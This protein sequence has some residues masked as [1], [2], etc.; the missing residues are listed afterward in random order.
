M[1]GT[2]GFEVAGETHWEAI[3]RRTRSPAQAISTEDLIALTRVEGTTFQDEGRTYRFERGPAGGQQ[4]RCNVSEVG[5]SPSATKFTATVTY[6]YAL[7]G[8]FFGSRVPVTH[9]VVLKNPSNIARVFAPD[10][11]ATTGT[12]NVSTIKNLRKIFATAGI[13]PKGVV[14]FN[15]CPLLDSGAAGKSV[16]TVIAQRLLRSTTAEDARARVFQSLLERAPAARILFGG[17]EAAAFAARVGFKL[18]A[19]VS[20]VPD[21]KVRIAQRGDVAR[22]RRAVAILH[23]ALLNRIPTVAVSLAGIWNATTGDFP[24]EEQLLDLF[25]RSEFETANR[26]SLLAF[27]RANRAAFNS[28][29]QGAAPAAPAGRDDDDSDS[30]DAKDGGDTADDGEVTA[31]SYRSIS[32]D[33]L[34]EIGR[35][36]F[37]TRRGREIKQFLGKNAEGCRQFARDGLAAIEAFLRSHPPAAAPPATA[38]GTATAATRGGGDDDDGEEE[39]VIA[40]PGDSSQTVSVDLLHEALS[41]DFRTRRGRTI[42]AL[43]GVDTAAEAREL[44]THLLTRA[45][46]LPGSP[47]SPHTTVDPSPRTPQ[48]TP[49]VRETETDPL[50]EFSEGRHSPKRSLFTTTR[51]PDSPAKLEE[52]GRFVLARLRDHAEHNAHLRDFA[53]GEGILALLGVSKLEDILQPI[54]AERE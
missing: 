9:I 26:E 44:A 27:F 7:S 43:L 23:G 41:V 52:I 21:T 20:T 19:N 28:V 5:E 53:P 11:S 29:L 51:T 32:I 12:H 18:S 17:E 13:D 3:L 48:R 24:S 15:P 22:G 2:E 16:E 30:D 6:A 8:N 1:R 25:A 33:L 14:I 38:T 36:N 31:T 35:T 4:W 45:G 54:T 34:H 37:T 46:R 47:G 40:L 49:V 42:K 10:G 39:A 50:G